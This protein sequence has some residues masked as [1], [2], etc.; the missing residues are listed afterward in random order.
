MR[1]RLVAI[2]CLLFVSGGVA[3]AQM[4]NGSESTASQVIVADAVI[5]GSEDLAVGRTVV[6]DASLSHISGD[7]IRYAWY[8]EGKAQPIS[9][10]VEAVYTP[11]EPGVITFRL[12]VSS[13]LPSGDALT[14]EALHTVTVYRRKIVLVVDASVPPEK[15]ATH[16]QTAADAGVFLRVL[17]P[18]PSATPLGDE[19]LLTN[20]LSEQ[21]ATLAGAN[22][23]VLWTEG[24]T[25]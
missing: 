5:T 12:V 1:M 10:T 20:L 22:A 11:E 18:A 15:I 2:G 13:T 9:E 14:A 7:A 8:I 6:L 21:S 4:P 3:L 17:Q 23:I 24:I 16:R 25:G 19:E